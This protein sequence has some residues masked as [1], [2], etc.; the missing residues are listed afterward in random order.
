M[1]FQ[2]YSLRC[3]WLAGIAPPAVQDAKYISSQIPTNLAYPARKQLPPCP[4]GAARPAP[5]RY[6]LV[7]IRALLRDSVR[8]T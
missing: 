2:S 1:E 4:S 8:F 3:G 7:R 6:P 5:R